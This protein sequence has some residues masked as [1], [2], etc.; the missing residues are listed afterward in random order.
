[1]ANQIP[2]IFDWND[3]K[4]VGVATIEDGKLTITVTEAE[5]LEQLN[6]AP[7]LGEATTITAVSVGFRVRQDIEYIPKGEDDVE[8]DSIEAV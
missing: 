4:P 2:V 1:M 5:I 6:V 8:A 7:A 3:D